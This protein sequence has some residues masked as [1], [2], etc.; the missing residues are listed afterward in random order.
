MAI[1]KDIRNL[2][3]LVVAIVIVVVLWNTIRFL[4][5]LAIFLIAVYIVYMF[6]KGKL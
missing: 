6:L 5:G 4:A 2:V 3:L 1:S